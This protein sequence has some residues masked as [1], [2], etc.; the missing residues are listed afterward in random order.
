[1]SETRPPSSNDVA[2]RLLGSMDHLFD[3]FH[4]KILRP[5]MI[6]GRT[7]AFGFILILV[8]VLVGV[9]GLEGLIRLFNSYAFAAHQW[10]PYLIVGGLFILI[11]LIIWR[12]RR[13]VSTR[14]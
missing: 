2:G 7:V 12:R 10:A 4:D 3:L 6:L 13:P 9:A 14:K 8:G 1:M 11:G 5:I